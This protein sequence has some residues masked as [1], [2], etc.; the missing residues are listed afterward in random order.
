M[1]DLKINLKNPTGSVWKTVVRYSDKNK[2][3]FKLYQNISYYK[4]IDSI[5]NSFWFGKFV[6]KHIKRG[7][8]KLAYKHINKAFLALKLYN[9]KLPPLILVEM[10]E[11]LRPLFK[12]NNFFLG[13]KMVQY[14]KITSIPKQYLVVL[15]WICTDFKESYSKDIKNDKTI[16][17]PLWLFD[18]LMKFES[19]PKHDKL[20]AD[21]EN[22]YY[23]ASKTQDNVRY[24]WKQ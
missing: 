12:L 21:R 13:R 9:S 4:Y 8:K 22:Y 17:Y 10:L 1:K 24:T 20:T 3:Q 23:K 5:Y 15:K 6:N 16:C 19:E 7:D 14:P 2:K 11:Q 18:R